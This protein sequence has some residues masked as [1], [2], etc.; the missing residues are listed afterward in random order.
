MVRINNPNATEEIIKITFVN[1]PTPKDS[2]IRIVQ[3]TNPVLRINWEY[4]SVYWKDSNKIKT[5]AKIRIV[6]NSL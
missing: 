3:I 5:S 4:L 2:L 1:P 6:K